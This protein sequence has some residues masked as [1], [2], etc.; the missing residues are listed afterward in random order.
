MIIPGA[1]NASAWRASGGQKPSAIWYY[2]RDAAE[3][4]LSQRQR[5]PRYPQRAYQKSDGTAKVRD[6][7]DQRSGETL[8]RP[9]TL[10]D[11]DRWIEIAANAYPQSFVD[12]STRTGFA[13]RVRNTLATPE[14]FPGMRYYG[15]FR[16]GALLGG[17]RLHDFAMNVYGKAIP[18]GGVGMVAVDLMHKKQRV[19]FDMVR[20]YLRHYRE[21][22]AP[23]AVLWPFRPDFYR[24]MGFGYGAPASRFT[25][26]PDV[27]PAGGERE[28]V[29]LLSRDDV[30]ALM[31]CY[32]RIF[33]QTHGLIARTEREFNRLFDGPANYIAGFREGDQL[34]GYMVFSFAP[35]M[36]EN[37]TAN[38]LRLSTELMYER[39]DVLL[40]LCGFLRSQSDQV[41]RIVFDSQD[42]H[43]HFLFSDPRN[44]SLGFYP[45]AYHETNAQGI[46]V[47]YRVLDMPGVF[48]HLAEHDFGGQ[49]ASVEFTITDSFLP[50]NEGRY[51]VR[52]DRGQAQIIS[53]GGESDV[54]VSLDVAEFSSLLMGSVTFSAL[55]AY[56]LASVSDPATVPMLTRM[57]H[58]DTP[59][60]C[61]TD[62]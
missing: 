27:L 32:Q 52:V 8:I 58:A 40:A 34:R 5:K 61:V 38:E 14:A 33:G 56:G 44:G 50:E 48:A 1:T 59:P 25:I 18:T 37:F 7:T 26:S 17:M 21:R 29:A 46:G 47:M 54:A 57:F 49:T 24:K 3:H 30:P 28:R 23:L 51:V 53:A 55:H 10:D 41:T 9:L 36:P 19:A 2:A 15:L 62:F 20:W 43:L 13:E 35:A 11:L 22:G 4:S 12:V 45:H 16:S 6:T 31:A 39:P 42:P 60:R